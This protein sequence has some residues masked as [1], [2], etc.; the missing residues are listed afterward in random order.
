ML[1]PR[2]D[3]GKAG[4]DSETDDSILINP[5]EPEGKRMNRKKRK[6]VVR[7]K[8]LSEVILSGSFAVRK[9]DES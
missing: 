2:H 9:T 7:R 8:A 6:E 1:V 5:I 4:I 3:W